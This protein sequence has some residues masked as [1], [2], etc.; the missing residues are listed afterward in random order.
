MDTIAA[1]L[2]GA[3]VLYVAAGLMVAIAFAVSGVTQVQAAPVTIGARI[4]LVPGALMLW[5]IVLTRWLK[6]RR[7]P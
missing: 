5:P 7:T 3:L 1:I 6:V 4:L 2:F